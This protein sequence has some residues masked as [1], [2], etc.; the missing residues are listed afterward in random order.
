MFI[1]VILFLILVMGGVVFIEC[2]QKRSVSSWLIE[3]LFDLRR[4]KLSKKPDNYQGIK[5]QRQRQIAYHLDNPETLVGFPTQEYDVDGMQVFVINDQK[6]QDQ[7]I[8]FYLYGSV[9]LR[10]PEKFHFKTIKQLI[11]LT[12]AKLVFPNFQ[13]APY[14]TYQEVYP[15]L[16]KAYKRYALA[17]K[18]NQTSFIGDSSGGG[19]VLALAQY[20]RDHKE[21]PQP[22][23]II[24]LSPWLDVSLANSDYQELEPVEAY[25]D[26]RR[27]KDIGELWAGGKESM[28]HPYVSPLYGDYR[29]LPKIISFAGTREIFLPD[30]KRFHETLTQQEV[31]NQLII[32]DNMI[33]AYVIFPIREA[34]KALRQ[35][36]AFVLKG[37]E[38]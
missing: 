33:H 15:K 38:S 13:K 9:Y 7:P 23:Q 16:A 29:G 36:A 19:M 3:K 37:T 10:R 35:I 27:L 17:T 22:S 28:T 32:E 11:T 26:A 25:L 24:T 18:G 14:V 34:R 5:T 4:Y 30:I 8:I 21:A 6:T 2:Y 31:P 12:D 1:S 20:L